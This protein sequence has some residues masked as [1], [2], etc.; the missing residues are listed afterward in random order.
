[1]PDPD[2]QDLGAGRPESWAHL[3]GNVSLFAHLGKRDLRRIARASKIARVS[4]GQVIVREGFTAE[5]FY[6]LLTGTAT[7]ERGGGAPGIALSRGDFFGELGLLDGA[8]RTATVIA[9]TDLWAARLPRESFLRLIDRQPAIARGL[10]AAMAERLRRVE[11]ELHSR[12]DDQ[13]VPD[14]SEVSGGHH[15]GR[16]MNRALKM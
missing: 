1:M 6:I 13:P 8:A 10:L 5:A 7:V 15:R 9:D 3:L 2:D 11:A 4:A 14:T 12:A 16:P